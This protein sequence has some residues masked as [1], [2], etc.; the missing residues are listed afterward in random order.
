M[1]TTCPICEGTGW[2]AEEAGGVR[3]MVLCECQATQQKTE[4]LASIR[5]PG[6]YEHCDFDNFDTDL[7]EKPEEQYNRS[8]QQAK[9][10]VQRYVAEFPANVDYGLLLMG[11]CGVGKTHLGV[12]A[13]RA[14]AAKGHE[15]LFYDFR[16]LLKEIQNSYNPVSQT[17]EMQVLE[18]VLRAEVLLLDDFG[19]I[20]PSD[21]VRDIVGHILNS[22]Y[23]EKRATLITT[24]FLDRPPSRDAE[25]PRFPSGQA[26]VRT[27]D[28]LADRIG[29]R[30][31][32]RLYEMCRVVEI[33]A[34]DY[35]QRVRQ[36]Q[37]R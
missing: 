5:I 13:L 28:S 12:A 10:T 2:K 30:V 33:T 18:P 9:L 1:A 34:P 24:N 11:T 4:R 32:S 14:L 27:E 37:Y 29:E 25:A 17:T 8:L 36:A 15:C 19:A 20:K 16:E 21:W 22:R 3:R 23:N 35:R 7:Y 26:T 6:R 31:R